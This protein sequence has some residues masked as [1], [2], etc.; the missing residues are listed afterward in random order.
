MRNRLPCNIAFFAA[1]LVCLVIFIKKHAPSCKFNHWSPAKHHV[2]GTETICAIQDIKV[3]RWSSSS[4]TSGFAFT[5]PL[6]GSIPQVSCAWL[7]LA[8]RVQSAVWWDRLSILFLDDPV[9]WSNL[10]GPQSVALMVQWLSNSQAIVTCTSTLCFSDSVDDIALTP[11]S[12]QI[13][14]FCFWS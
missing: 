5:Q 6:P 10:L 3:C 2:T 14:E 12:W 8:V 13:Q 7:I 1:M 4:W 11:V 9:F